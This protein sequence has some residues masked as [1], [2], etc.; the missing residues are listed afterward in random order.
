M[1]HDERI[2]RY[3]ITY[4]ENQEKLEVLIPRYWNFICKIKKKDSTALEFLDRSYV[5]TF[6]DYR[7][8]IDCR[9][10]LDEVIKNDNELIDANGLEKYLKYLI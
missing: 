8:G 1:F 6:R 5:W 7:Q 4:R 3:M 9:L 2:K 10:E